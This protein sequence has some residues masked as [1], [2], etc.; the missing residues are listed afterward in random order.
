MTADPKTVLCFGDSLTWGFDPRGG[1][2]RVRY[3][4]SERWTRRLQAELGS[5][6][7]VIEDGL[8]GRT[9]V[10]DDPVI[11]DMNGLAQLPTALKTHM[12]LDLVVI[13]L[14][15]NDAKVRFGLNGDEIAAVSGAFSTS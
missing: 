9:T 3:G 15:T 14:G 7:Y 4:F 5:S 2:D 12:P 6:Y 13:L 1:E 10:F 11:G 8:S